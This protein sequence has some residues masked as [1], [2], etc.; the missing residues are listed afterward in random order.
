M[1]LEDTVHFACCHKGCGHVICMKREVEREY[2][3]NGAWFK[4]PAGHD[5]HFTE[6]LDKVDELEKSLSHAERRMNN[7]REMAMDRAEEVQELRLAR[8]TCPMCGGRQRT[9]QGVARHLR[10]DH[11]ALEVV[12]LED[13]EATA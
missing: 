3:R 1:P 13:E 2:R 11:L 10:R 5:Q 4:C 8:R 12:E 6:T 9:W 7:W